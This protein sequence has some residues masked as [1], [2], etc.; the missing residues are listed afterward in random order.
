MFHVSAF[1]GSHSG[2]S[3]P[4]DTF[5]ARRKFEETFWKRKMS[6]IAHMV[7]IPL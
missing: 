2:G 7:S 3:Q 4:F 1:C 5:A 6:Q